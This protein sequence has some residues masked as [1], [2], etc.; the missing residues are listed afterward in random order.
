MFGFGIVLMHIADHLTRRKY[1]K[2][3]RTRR[4]RSENEEPVDKK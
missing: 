2:E 1:D 4:R 3:K